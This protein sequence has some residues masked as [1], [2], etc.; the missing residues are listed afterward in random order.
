MRSTHRLSVYDLIKTG[1]VLVLA[2]FLY[3]IF[4]PASQPESMARVTLPAYPGAEFEW[5]Y[6]SAPGYC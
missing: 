1:L 2:V 4:N 6:D 5:K 3:T